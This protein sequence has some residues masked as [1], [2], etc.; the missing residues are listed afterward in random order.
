[1]TRLTLSL[2]AGLLALA[3]VRAE[4]REPGAKAKFGP[5]ALVGA[6]TI[7]SGEKDGKKEPPERIKGTTV[8]FTKDTITVTDK[9]KKHA[10]V[11]TYKLDTS[12]KPCKIAM[13]STQGPRAGELAKGLVVKKGDTVTLIYAV[14]G[15]DEPTEFKT[16][17][18][19]MLFVL[20][21]LKKK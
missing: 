7:E 5:D 11:A 3:A 18:K 16:K 12:A 10:Y 4:D 17:N 14:P 9:T 8:L 15:G 2:A 6:Y 13:K 19:Q 1:M 20:K 21:P